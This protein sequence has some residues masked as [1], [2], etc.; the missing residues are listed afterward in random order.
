MHVRISAIAIALGAAIVAVPAYAQT[1]PAFAAWLTEF[2]TEALD[3]GIRNETFEASFAGVAP[4]P[5]IIELDRRQPESTLTFEQYVD[6]IV[7]KARVDRGRARL[8]EN[9]PLLREVAAKFGVQPR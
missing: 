9:S 5:R 7:S 2:R 3:A 4:I 6:R 8:S 1:D